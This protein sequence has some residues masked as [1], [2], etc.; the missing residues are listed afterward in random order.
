MGDPARHAAVKGV[1]D[2]VA[3]SAAARPDHP[4]LVFHD[5]AAT[6][7]ELDALVDRSAAALHDLGVRR[8]DRVALLL[9]NIPEFV[10][11]LHGALR[12]GAIAV[13]LNV[14]LTPEELGY[15]LADAEASVVVVGIDLVPAI[16]AVRDRLGS[17]HHVLIVGPPPTPPGTRSLD[18]VLDGAGEPPP[19]DIESDDPAL[20]GYT[21]GTTD[22]PKG[23]V[24]THGNLL[25][26]LEQVQAVPA[27]REAES[28]V[29]LLV[30]PLF[31]IYGLNAALNVI[32]RE[33][34]TAV[35][36]E[37]FHPVETLRLVE[38]HGV[39]VLFGVP[40]TYA[41]WLAAARDQDF[42]LSSV[43][44]AVSGAAPLPE[45]V[46]VAF[47]ER[48][49]CVIWEGY[50]L[51][52]TAPVVTTN[53][54]AEAAKG[55]SIGLP[56]PG[57]EIRLL[58]EDGTD[59]VEGDPG[60]I[61][62]RGPNVF[63]GYWRRPEETEA[64]FLDDWFRTGDVAYRDHDGFLFLVDRTK[65][66]II[67]SGFNVFPREVEEAVASHP[68]VA[69]C[70]VIGVPDERTGEA[71]KAWVVPRR[72]AAPTEEDILEHCRARLARFKLPREVEFVEALPKHVTG[73]V[74]RR[75]LKQ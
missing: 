16:L 25:A 9:G 68:D 63:A 1:S 10:H 41:A 28:D 61:L 13:P 44:L 47:R 57:V 58:D 7:R 67:V 46:L 45:E 40:Q 32:L 70:T 69:E 60:E 21:A 5:R 34:A 74:V 56:L 19:V 3:R 31:H 72:G 12:L 29:A 51:T 64:V 39:T 71:P 42:D 26:N 73:K 48:F 8:G 54:L 6:Y 4:A 62:V 33:G 27:L 15:V 53:A 30:L 14:L 59:V 75:V 20:I 37:R 11:V 2:L 66:L 22:D 36:V 43:R 18:E 38:R 35:L 52:E 24:L 49:G 55:G 65:D 17:L 23:A 50:G